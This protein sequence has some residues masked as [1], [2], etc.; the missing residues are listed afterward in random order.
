M[1][2]ISPFGPCRFS[3][4]EFCLAFYEST[5]FNWPILQ[6]RWLIQAAALIHLAHKFM[7]RARFLCSLQGR[8]R[9][10]A[11]LNSGEHEFLFPPL[12]FY[13]FVQ[14]AAV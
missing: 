9:D 4:S 12:F 3:S 7:G 13:I 6:I 5:S 2:L 11:A 8:K 1:L 10:A 14:A